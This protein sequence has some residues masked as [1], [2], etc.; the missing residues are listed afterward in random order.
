MEVG[1]LLSLQSPAVPAVGAPP[2]SVAVEDES[3]PPHAARAAVMATAL[4]SPMVRLRSM[5]GCP[6]DG[7][8]CDGLG[9]QSRRPRRRSQGHCALIQ[10]RSGNLATGNI[11]DTVAT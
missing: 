7:K 11:S 6:S 5:R 2:A 1:L 9:L 3:E 8:A 10:Y 4:I